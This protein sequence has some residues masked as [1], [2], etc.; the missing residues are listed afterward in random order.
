MDDAPEY[1]LFFSS[2]ESTECTE[3]EVPQHSCRDDFLFALS[4]EGTGDIVAEMCEEYGLPA[5]VYGWVIQSAFI[6]GAKVAGVAAYLSA[7]SRSEDPE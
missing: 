7:T 2:G 6:N 5:Q 4:T 3:K 1:I